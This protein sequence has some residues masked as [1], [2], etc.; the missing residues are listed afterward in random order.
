MRRAVLAGEQEI[1]RGGLVP[2]AQRQEIQTQ[3]SHSLS[4]RQEWGP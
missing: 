2:L 1:L 4:L 3:V